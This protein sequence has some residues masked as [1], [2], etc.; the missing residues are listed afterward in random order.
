MQLRLDIQ[1][2]RALAVMMV[3]IFHINEKFLPGGFIGVDIFFV[4]SG[5]LI[6]KSIISSVDQGSFNIIKFF[7]GR[8]KRIAPAYYFMLV[9]AIIVA[10]LIYIPND[11]DT[12]Y[13]QLKRTFIFA[14]NQLFANTDD[15][16]GAKSYENPLLHTWS[17]GIEMQFY[18]FLP[19]FLMFLPS[20]LRIIAFSLI[21]ITFLIYTEYNIRILDQKSQMYFSLVARSVEFIIGIGINLVTFVSLKKRWLRE[22]LS[23]L[24]LSVIILSAILLNS[25]SSFPGLLSLPACFATAYIIAEQNTS[26]NKILS[27]SLPNYLGKI[28]YSLYLW[29]WPVL[30]FYRYYTMR[31]DLHIFEILGLVAIFLM[32]SLLSFYLIEERFRF[33]KGLKFY[34]WFGCTMIMTIA[35]WIGS[36]ILNKELVDIPE[37]YITPKPFNNHNH[38]QYSGY[39]L[40]GDK[41]SRPDDHILVIGDSHGLAMTPFLES[42][43]KQY[44]F[45]FQSISMNRYPPIPGLDIN[46]LTI[47]PYP[48]INIGFIN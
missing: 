47:E 5:F 37:F 46:K 9:F 20:R 15:Y 21:F 24:A 3:I 4:I 12:F 19:V 16:F 27:T 35:I 17:L 11:F 26:L 43:G 18:L 2:L 13:H 1:G 14:S 25:N 36:K 28:S 41:N 40:L 23:L 48:F 32:F 22:L 6:S 44:H 30:S 39:E 7:E 34:I 8:I 38:H 45:N 10:C 33:L 42:V 31:Y 29:H